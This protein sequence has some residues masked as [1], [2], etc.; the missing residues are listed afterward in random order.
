MPNDYLIFGGSL[1]EQAQ[2]EGSKIPKVVE[3]CITE[4]EKTC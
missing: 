4:I 2:R 1:E 3:E